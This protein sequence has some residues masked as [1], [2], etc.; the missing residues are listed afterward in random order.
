MAA[1]LRVLVVAQDLLALTGLAALLREQKGCD[2]VG[3]IAA[4]GDVNAGIEVYLPDAVAWD[5]GW[6]LPSGLEQLSN[7]PENEPPTVALVADA[8][9]AA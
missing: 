1:N 9:D 6:D 7:L 3:Q 5:L 2:V 4:D 8:S